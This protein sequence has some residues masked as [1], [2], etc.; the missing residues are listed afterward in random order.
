MST[1]GQV[2]MQTQETGKNQKYFS[3]FQTIRRVSTEEGVGT[4]LKIVS[5]SANILLFKFLRL[6]R[7]L[8][9]P[10]CTVALTNAVTFGV[11]GM[12]ARRWGN[13]SVADVARNGTFAGLVRVIALDFEL[14]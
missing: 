1:I 3:T 4:I 2:L 5:Y 7:G 11:Y 13:D 9:T 12:M 8:S 14:F 6:Y 10:L